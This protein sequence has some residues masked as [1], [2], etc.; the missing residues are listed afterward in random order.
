MRVSQQESIRNE[1]LNILG[2]SEDPPKD[3]PEL[4]PV[5][6]ETAEDDTGADEDSASGEDGDEEEVQ[7]DSSE[8]PKA[9]EHWSKED[10]ATFA[11]LEP[12]AQQVMV[13]MEKNMQS[14]MTQKTEELAQHR[15]RYESFDRFFD[16][17][18]GYFP[19]VERKAFEQQIMSGLPAVADT[20]MRL[21]QAPM[22]TLMELADAYGV[23]EKLSESLME[24]DFTDPSRELERKNRNLSEENKRLMSTRN[25][26]QAIAGQKIIDD[27]ANVKDTEGNLLHP[28]FD[29]IKSYMGALMVADDKL[30]ID[31]AYEKALWGTDHRSTLLE[32]EREKWKAE[33]TRQREKKIPAARKAASQASTRGKGRANTQKSEEEPMSIGDSLRKTLAE[34]LEREGE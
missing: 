33:E 27:F 3:L 8:V 6:D 20:Y 29:E 2:N 5:V 28:H 9:P 31:T 12:D 26:G 22:E 13:Q 14:G 18:H 10:Q 16:T 1:M 11:K 34:Q 25:R 7:D 24:I 4:P 30:T 23:S 21:Q 19:S 17:Y 15:Q 32:K